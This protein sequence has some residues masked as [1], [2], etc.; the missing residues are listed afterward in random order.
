MQRG[1]F[2][3]DRIL[4]KKLRVD[5]SKKHSLFAMAVLRGAADE[6]RHH[7]ESTASIRLKAQILRRALDADRLDEAVRVAA[8][9]AAE[10]RAPDTAQL[11]PKAYYD[12]YLSVCAELRVLEMYVMESARRGA[13]VLELYERVQETPL[14]LP[15]LY[16][17][18]TA[19]SVYVKSEQ[20]PAKDVLRD[21]VEMCAAVQHPQRGLFLRAYLSQMMKDK[22]PDSPAPESGSWQMSQ[23]GENLSADDAAS[24]S[25]GTIAD[26][27]EFV[28]RNFTEMNRLWVRM[29]NNVPVHDEEAVKKERLELRL[30]VGS[31]FTT[32]GRLLSNN[33][34]MYSGKVLPAII[35]QI[36]N[37]R[38]AIAQEYLADCVAQVFPDDFQLATL[39]AFLRMCATLVRGANLRTILTSVIDRLTRYA[40]SSSS[41]ADHVCSVDAFGIFNRHLPAVL[42]HQRHALELPNRLHIFQ[43][44]MRFVLTI[45]PEKTDSVDAVLALTVESTYSFVGQGE[46]TPY[47]EINGTFYSARPG[48]S[49][50]SGGPQPPNGSVN[51]RPSG[52]PLRQALTDEESR[53]IVQILSMPLNTYQDMAIA[54]RLN[55]F[56]V[57]QQMLSF[58]KQHMLAIRVLRSVREY[59]PCIESVNQLE[60]LFSYVRPLV[61]AAQSSSADDPDEVQDDSYSPAAIFNPATLSVHHAYLSAEISLGT[62]NTASD[63]K[64]QTNNDVEP[65]LEPTSLTNA[66]QADPKQQELQNQVFQESQELVARIVF[67][68]HNDSLQATTS[69]YEVIRSHLLRGDMRQRAITL[70]PLVLASLRLALR[71]SE[72]AGVDPDARAESSPSSSVNALPVAILMF[73]VGCVDALSKEHPLLALRLH[74]QI[75]V[76]ASCACR[77]SG[78]DIVYDSVSRAYLLFENHVNTSSDQFTGLELITTTLA[79]IHSSLA[80][81]SYHAL[82]RRAVKHAQHLLTRSDQCLMLLTCTSLYS[83]NCNN[84]VSETTDYLVKEEEIEVVACVDRAII[85][86]E[87]V[88]S[89][90]ERFFLLV[91]VANRMIQL[92]EGGCVAVT[93]KDRLRDVMVSLKDIVAPRQTKNVPLGLVA[94]RRR[95][96]LVSH[97]RSHPNMFSFLNVSEL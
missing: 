21:L 78:V 96:L 11:T 23:L 4:Q 54:L 35:E 27:V 19:G 48:H 37:C 52:Q 26:S 46:T 79:Q 12:V 86:A 63:T 31:N 91:S 53:L 32:L 38:D 13:P 77:T 14:V 49:A 7:R 36:V 45:E 75:A 88:A 34:Q 8:D 94:L 20:A 56:T 80:R 83:E 76:A 61:V 47:E 50:T 93:E 89:I 81:E 60:R 5:Q 51:P 59:A 70:P 92:F 72:M 90:G 24:P 68:V 71:A 84:L 40:A 28:L 33:L 15:R 97:I 69:L 39:D 95:A 1:R 57:L 82:A 42:D 22:L 66:D 10:L 16:L 41:A 74:L 44:L 65:S 17:L 30:L 55:Y 43:S 62:W 9:V 3:N 6:T 25:G 64:P 87:A 18:V 2:G 85:A 73:A 58:D 29:K 67:L